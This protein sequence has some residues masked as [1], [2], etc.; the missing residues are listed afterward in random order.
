MILGRCGKKLVPGLREAERPRTKLQELKDWNR[1][2]DP[3]GAL[4][5]LRPLGGRWAAPRTCAANN[6]L[7]I[8][9][10]DPRELLGPLH[11]DAF[12]RDVDDRP[13]L[14]IDEVV[15]GL[16]MGI[17]HRNPFGESELLQQPLLHKEM[18]GVVDGRS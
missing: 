18:K 13:R 17:K 3:Q 5:P 6:D 14:V 12:P 16:Y 10:I 9:Y 2:N 1:W 8:A 11:A 7:K 4:E 15:V